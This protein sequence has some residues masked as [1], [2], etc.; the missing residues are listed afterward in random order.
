MV[1]DPFLLLGCEEL[2][3]CKVF[4]VKFANM[5]GLR[6]TFKGIQAVIGIQ[7]SIDVK[8]HWCWLASSGEVGGSWRGA[9]NHSV[10]VNLTVLK[11]GESVNIK[12]GSNHISA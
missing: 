11:A 12:Y 10:G 1:F 5:Y 7:V 6:R 8:V 2:G 3:I 9:G 4:Q